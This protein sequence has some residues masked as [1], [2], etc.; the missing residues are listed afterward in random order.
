MI[1]ACLHFADRNSYLEI[2]TRWRTIRVSLASRVYK[3][4]TEAF[5]FR[6]SGGKGLGVWNVV[7]DERV[8]EI[9]PA[10]FC[11]TLICRLP[12]YLMFA[13]HSA[14]SLGVR[15]H[16]FERHKFVGTLAATVRPFVLMSSSRV[17]LVARPLPPSSNP[18]VNCRVAPRELSKRRQFVEFVVWFVLQG[19]WGCTRYPHCYTIIAAIFMQI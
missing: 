5:C 18:F 11:G 10:P 9:R 12:Y 1:L 17:M 6:D 16:H 3:R 4:V 13:E 14:V 19:G 2:E 8:H 15:R 7:V